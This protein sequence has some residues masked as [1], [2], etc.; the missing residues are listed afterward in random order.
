MNN[1][2][3]LLSQTTGGAAGPGASLHDALKPRQAS[4]VS[5]KATFVLSEVLVGIA[6]LVAWTSP[7]QA[8][9][10]AIP[11]GSFESPVVPPVRFRIA[12]SAALW[13]EPSGLAA[14]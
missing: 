10:I 13:R 8:G 9:T 11:N 1:T 4:P 6:A 14:R 12:L 2:H 7:L 5:S 3:M